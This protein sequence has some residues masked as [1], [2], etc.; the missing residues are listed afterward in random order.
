MFFFR[1]IN[2]PFQ[3][4]DSSLV[5]SST[6]GAIN[7]LKQNLNEEKALQSILTLFNF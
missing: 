6:D 1:N 2:K 7:I 4:D 3:I 5:C